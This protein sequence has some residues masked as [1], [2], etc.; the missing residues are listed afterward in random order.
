MAQPAEQ[1][2]IDTK[3]G[4]ALIVSALGLEEGLKMAAQP[5]MIKPWAAKHASACHG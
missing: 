1:L 3:V 2:T 5:S 4:V